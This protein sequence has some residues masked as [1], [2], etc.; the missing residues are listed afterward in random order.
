[1]TTENEDTDE[2]AESK[3]VDD[4][5]DG[6]VRLELGLLASKLMFRA[7]N[8][9]GNSQ[10]ARDAAD[11]LFALADPLFEKTASFARIARRYIEKNHRG[12][13]S[14]P[15]EAIA[16]KGVFVDGLR[17]K[18]SAEAMAET[19]IN[20]LRVCRLIAPEG[21]PPSGVSWSKE[22]RK[23]A[24]KLVTQAIQ[25][26]LHAGASDPERIAKAVMR[27]LGCSAKTADNLFAFENRRSSSES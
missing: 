23:V 13:R 14:R 3:D 15:Q 16:L 18:T 7:R 17:E 2:R 21:V 8:S 1:V 24:E 20:W 22:E 25:K 26:A 10:V 4:R 19:A 9:G 5:A 11:I 6:E 27:A 12:A